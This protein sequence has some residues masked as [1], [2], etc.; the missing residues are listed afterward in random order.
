[1]KRNS[2]S[3]EIWDGIVKLV[4]ITSFESMHHVKILG[5]PRENRVD[6]SRIEP[7]RG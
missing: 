7:N 5:H 3:G 4:K 1:M 2:T 6:F